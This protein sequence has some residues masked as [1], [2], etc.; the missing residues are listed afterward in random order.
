MIKD[1]KQA[2]EKIRCALTPA[3]IFDIL[4]FRQSE[5]VEWQQAKLNEDYERGSSSKG[6]VLL[7]KKNFFFIP[8]IS[9]PG[10]TTKKTIKKMFVKIPI[11][12]IKKVKTGKSLFT[13]KSQ[14]LT[15]K[16]KINKRRILSRKQKKGRE[17]FVLEEDAE[18]LANEIKKM[19]PEIKS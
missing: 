15:I 6:L 7:T 12:D 18:K 13:R 4:G 2:L 19:N 1:L 3:Q 16:G 14:I 8:K 9:W 17:T 5:L 11:A 10:K